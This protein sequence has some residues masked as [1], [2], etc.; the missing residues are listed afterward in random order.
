[1]ANA[2]LGVRSS[3]VA[4]K[5]AKLSQP[6]HLQGATGLISAFVSQKNRLPVRSMASEESAAKEAVQSG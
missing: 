5:Q 2:L 3:V 6:G 1:M 4:F